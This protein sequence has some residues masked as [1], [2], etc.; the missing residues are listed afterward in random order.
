MKKQALS[1]LVLGAA[2]VG[3]SALST[4]VAAATFP[5]TNVGA[6]PDNNPAGRDVAFSVSGVT[7]PIMTVSLSMTMTHS[8][9]GD[10][11]AVLISPAG[12]ARTVV[13][14]RAGMNRANTDGSSSDLSGIYVFSDDA[15]GDF[16]TATASN[17]LAP[18]AY[19]PSATG[20]TRSDAGGCAT[21][22]TGVFGGLTAAEANGNWTLNVSDLAAMD[23]G[24]ITAAALAIDAPDRVFRSGFNA[25]AAISTRCL[26]K[27]QADFTGDGL[28]DYALARDV[29]GTIHWIIQENQGD[30]TGAATPTEFDLGVTAT[31]YVDSVD[32]DGDRIADAMVWNPTTGFTIRRSS[33]PASA[34]LIVAFGQS[35]NDLPI[36]SGDYDGD[37]RDDLA[38]YRAPTLASG[39]GPLQ[40]LVRSSATGA[41]STI[42]LG[43]GVDGDQ[44]VSAGFD[45][46][47]DALADIAVQRP[48]PMI[49]GGATYTVYDGRSGEVVI[50]TFP[51][52]RDTDF[53]VPGNHAGSA[54]FD[55]TASRTE[56]IAGQPGKSFY[57][58]DT[59]TGTALP[60]VR[61]G[62]ANDVRIG[63]DYD[64]DGL[65]DYAIWRSSPTVGMSQFQIRLSTN[66]ATV[67]MVPAG[68]DHDFPVAG[69]KVQ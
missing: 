7:G 3:V 69:S 40:L 20:T 29:S 61:F 66:T 39:P 51:F 59:G 58:R 65:S 43:T 17:P 44:Y 32:I 53:I 19:L 25:P 4:I 33:R 10:L 49:A 24:S 12:V 11:R 54:L 2:A 21:S 41:V 16:W 5:G 23:T 28:T 64:G 36:E 13:F 15:A 42:A 68:I 26:N 30:G 56:T 9:V 67:W 8:W 6:I 22:L 38:V 1:V 45:F 63:G 62:G 35:D 47:G 46:T 31:D 37:M 52:Q 14:S 27:V 60:V 18:G 57:T 50:N 48:D 34:P 55:I